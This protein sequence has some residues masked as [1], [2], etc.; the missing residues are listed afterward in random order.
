MAFKFTIGRK[1]GTGFGVLLVLTLIALHCSIASGLAGRSDRS[2]KRSTRSIA[3]QQL[4]ERH[5]GTLVV[6]HDAS[7]LQRKLELQNLVL[8]C[9]PQATPAHN[10]SLFVGESPSTLQ[11]LHAAETDKGRR[12]FPV[13]PNAEPRTLRFAQHLL[14]IS[15]RHLGSETKQDEN[16]K[17]IHRSRETLTA[18]KF[19]IYSGPMLA[20]SSFARV[21]DQFLGLNWVAQDIPKALLAAR[22]LNDVDSQW[23]AK[24]FPNNA[25]AV[26]AEEARATFLSHQTEDGRSL[27]FAGLVARPIDQELVRRA[28]EQGNAL[29]LGWMAEIMGGEDRLKFELLFLSFF[30]FSS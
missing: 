5:R 27:V 25:A 28:A 16:M 11:R 18:I 23:L 4:H 8:A 20:A 19:G 14:Q 21:T 6:L 3:L 13:D 1:I 9:G 12:L 26:S 29:A 15:H 24:L 22:A 30:L 10:Q 7:A 2:R 17:R